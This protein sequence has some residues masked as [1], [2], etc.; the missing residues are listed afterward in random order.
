MRSTFAART[1]NGLTEALSGLGTEVAHYE[2]GYGNFQQFQANTGAG[3]AYRWKNSNNAQA[4]F[5]WADD[6]DLTFF[7]KT[8]SALTNTR[9]V[10]GLATADPTSDTFTGNFICLRYSSAGC[11]ISAGWS[12]SLPI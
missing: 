5:L 10:F 2:A 1:F 11:I 12:G 7:I 6:F 9:L 4:E 8:F 3:N